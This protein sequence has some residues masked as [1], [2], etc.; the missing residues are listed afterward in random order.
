MNIKSMIKE[1]SEAKTFLGIE[2]G[3]T[4]MKAVLISAE[5][6]MPIASSSHQWENL[7]Q[8]AV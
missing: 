8:D 4:R 1:I 3:Y 2:F 7:F 5:S 6:H